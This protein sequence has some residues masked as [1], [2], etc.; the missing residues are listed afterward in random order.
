MALSQCLLLQ[1]VALLLLV[2]FEISPVK[3]EEILSRQRRVI[4]GNP[5]KH[6]EYPWAVSIRGDD[7]YSKNVFHVCGATI[8]NE[9][10]LISAG[11]CFWKHAAKKIDRRFISDMRDPKHWHIIAGEVF[12]NMKNSLHDDE[13]SENN[14]KTDEEIEV[15]E[16]EEEQEI[17]GPKPPARDDPYWLKMEMDF[18]RRIN[19]LLRMMRQWTHDYTQPFIHDWSKKTPKVEEKDDRPRIYLYHGPLTSWPL[20]DFPTS[21]KGNSQNPAPRNENGT[22]YHLQKIILHPNYSPND[23]EYDLA[24]LKLDSPLPLTNYT[25]PIQLSRQRNFPKPSE[26]CK[27]V[28]WGCTTPSSQAS[29]HA[30]SVQLRVLS[31]RECEFQYRFQAGLH[32]YHEF[33]A[34]YRNRGVG[35]CMG[36]SGSGLICKQNGEWALAGVASATHYKHPDKYPG[37]FTRVSYFHKWI[38]DTIHKY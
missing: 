27:L 22:H 23:I 19:E 36:D 13:D 9:Y 2:H 10:W 11:H 25:M 18:D 3:C 31:Q 1:I 5:V 26:N 17:Q 8:L 28:G 6:G 24:L 15:E 30:Q 7:P 14:D 37:L 29:S 4:G 12:V 32:P 20:H 38:N 16:E 34:G 33:C 35:I 21:N